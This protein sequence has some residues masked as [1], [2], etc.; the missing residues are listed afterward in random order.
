MHGGY[1][2]WSFTRDRSV[3]KQQ[4][5]PGTVKRIITFAR[6]FRSKIAAFLI[7][8]I[9][10][11]ALVVVTPLLLQR[12]IDDGVIPRNT[13]VVVITAL[14][15]GLMALIEAVLGLLKAWL[16]ARVGEG[17]I[18]RLRSDVFRHVQRMPLA[19]FTR[20]QTGSLVSRLNSDVIGAQQTFT[21]TLSSV[22]SSVVSLI[23]VLIT[24]LTLSWQITLLA[25]VILPIFIVPAQLVGRR[26]S[27]IAREAMQL[28]AQMGQTMTERF[29]VSGALLVK[30]FGRLPEE[31]AAFDDKARQVRDIGVRRSVYGAVLFT[32]LSLVTAIATALVYG[33]GGELAIRGS[34]QV[35]ALVAMASLLS[36][37]YGPLTQLSNV[38][39]T[40]MTAL[41]SFDR[42]FEVLDLEPMIADAPD[43]VPL[44][45]NANTITF[46][47]VAFRYPSADEVSLASLES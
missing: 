12:V 39:V 38:Q 21:S 37:L 10:N 16:F 19:F 35:G 43:A 36:R 34:L 15:V 27:V 13:R 24:M 22:V 45:A 3:T 42:V 23:A 8:T 28:N 17:I 32:A 4:L 47:N 46:E 20:A 29:N 41:V 18:F 14:L 25:L 31:S 7:V 1:G 5:T 9:I 2:G 30:I 11:A 40:V 33:V 44:P 6:P 26:L